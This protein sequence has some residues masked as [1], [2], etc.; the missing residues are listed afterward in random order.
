MDH[1]YICSTKILRS[2]RPVYMYIGLHINVQKTNWD[3]GNFEEIVKWSR[4][5]FVLVSPLTV[6]GNIVCVGACCVHFLLCAFSLSFPLSF[7]EPEL[8]T[9]WG[10]LQSQEPLTLLLLRTY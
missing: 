10:L 9:V 2:S 8:H 6:R 4:V 3:Y 1:I 5:L 7:G